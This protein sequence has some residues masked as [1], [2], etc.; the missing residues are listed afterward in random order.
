MKHI[1]TPENIKPYKGLLNGFPGVVFVQD[2][3]LKL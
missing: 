1:W 2:N 3:L